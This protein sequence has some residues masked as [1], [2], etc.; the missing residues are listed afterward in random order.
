M[1]RRLQR[2]IAGFMAVFAR[3]LAFLAAL[4]VPVP[5]TTT[6]QP[7]TSGVLANRQFLVRTPLGSGY[8]RYFGNG[9]LDGDRDA[10]R[11]LIVVHGVLRDADFYYDT[12]VIAANA[13]QRLD[14]TLVIA[15]QF[16][17]WSDLAGRS[18]PAGTLW[19]G[20]RWPG[21]S[22]AVS[23]APISTYDVF[24]AILARLSDPR[25]FPHLKEIVLAG[26]SAGGQIVQR[27][28]IVGNARQLDPGPHV[29]VHLIVSNPSSYFYFTDWRPF[30][31]TGCADFDR[32]RYGLA[33]APRY[34]TGSDAELEARY[35]KRWVT[36]LMGTS[37]TNRHESD[38]DRSC[39]GEA[40]GAFRFE[41]AKFFISYIAR[42]HP[43][44]TNQDFAFVRGVGHD[45][46]GMFASP[47]GVSAIFGG[48][49][50]RCAQHGPLR[51]L[52][53]VPRG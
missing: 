28:A 31:Q 5:V 1:S 51:M 8:A 42:R 4:L 15:P 37:D 27:Y 52:V 35:V 22:D 50:Q 12:G 40:Q 43:A 14:R 48:S 16:V 46:R 33:G 41:R 39:G 44:G 29:P 38:L 2:R 45:N 11:A 13:A 9:S 53:T 24:D 3:L 20:G 25:R 49:L 7:D 19:W 10:T 17:E 36:Y 21:G 30:P 32:W 34:V 26:H 47:C 23:P 18:V 6:P